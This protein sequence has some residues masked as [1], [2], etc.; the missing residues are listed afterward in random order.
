MEMNGNNFFYLK[1]GKQRRYFRKNILLYAYF[2]NKQ[3]SF[4]LVVLGDPIPDY[5]MNSYPEMSMDELADELRRV[6]E[7]LQ[8]ATM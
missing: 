4:F 5:L 1:K 6:G 8:L 3:A 7:Q 2:G